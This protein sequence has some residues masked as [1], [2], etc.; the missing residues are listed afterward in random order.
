MPQIFE[1]LQIL[2]SAYWNG[3]IKVAEQAD[4]AMWEALEVINDDDD[5]GE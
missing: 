2:K 3:H 5:E 4:V 1:A